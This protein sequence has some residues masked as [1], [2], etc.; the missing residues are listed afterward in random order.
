VSDYWGSIVPEL[1]P[2]STKL[3]YCGEGG[4]DA[5]SG[6]SWA[7]RKETIGGLLG[8]AYNPGDYLIV[9]PG[10]YR[11]IVAL[12]GDGK[13][14]TN[15]ATISVTH[16]S[17]VVTGTGTN[18]VAV[19]VQAGDRLYVPWL[20]HGQTAAGDGCAF[21]GAGTLTSAGAD[22]AAEII[23]F[24]DTV[25]TRGAYLIT[26]AAGAPNAVTL[27]DI[28]GV[29]WAVGGPFNFWVTS[30]EGS[31]EIESVDSDTQITLR[32]PW[33]GPS[34]TWT[35]ARYEGSSDGYEIIRPVHLVGDES[36]Q[37]TDGIGGV[38]RVTASTADT[39]SDR[40]YCIRCGTHDYWTIQGFQVDSALEQNIDISDCTHFSIEDIRSL[41]TASKEAG[42]EAHI[43]LRDA[44]DR[45][46]I[47]RCALFGGRQAW[48]INIASVLT[49]WTEQNTVENIYAACYRPFRVEDVNNTT[50]KNST[51]GMACLGFL[52]VPN[53]DT[54]VG[55]FIHDCE[56]HY[57]E[58]TAV[59]AVTNGNIVADFNNYWSNNADRFNV[60]VVGA[61][62]T[63]YLYLPDLPNLVDTYRYPFRFF[64]P[65]EW[66]AARGVQ[67]LYTANEDV[68][69][70]YRPI[71]DTKMSRG[72]QQEYHIERDADT[73]YGGEEASVKHPDARRTQF[74]IPTSGDPITVSVFVRYETNY[75][76]TLP[77]LIVGQPGQLEVEDVAVVAADTW[78]QLSVLFIP[79]IAPKY[80][81]VELVSNNTAGAGDYAVYWQRLSAI[82]EAG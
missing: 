73:T 47:R 16:N 29:G 69:G 67:G 81:W 15:R 64:P 26:G 11:E 60:G 56:I 71:T 40:N 17:K 62:N 44:V 5:N 18:W 4:N 31:Y 48:G 52:Y 78:K 36:G 39:S 30:C 21:D 61:T 27:T 25:Q 19:A 12:N 77:S 3:W 7:N 70:A 49:R 28:N 42:L 65:S 34:Y 76:G 20:A 43:Q 72:F 33:S 75:A 22:F 55:V 58:T 9:G 1:L 63:P 57:A 46:T 59:W 2:G 79:G 23:G 74:R 37:L 53:G 32:R 13:V 50:I 80:I 54:G 66:W 10:V 51:S 8:V 35:D 82:P 14:V 68:Y 38:V 41:S 6:D 45:C 24:C